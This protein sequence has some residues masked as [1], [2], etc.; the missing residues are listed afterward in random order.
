[1]LFILLF[2]TNTFAVEVS[3][4]HAILIDLDSGKTLYQ[5]D[6]Y[7]PVYPASTTKILTVIL[8]LENCDLNETVT[9]SFTAI[10]SVYAGGTTANIQEGET[11]TVRDL[12]CTLLVH[13]ANDAAYILAEHIGRINCQLCKYDE[14]SC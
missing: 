7:S 10:N 12:L 9:A 11:H 2:N 5:K 13:S 6:A 8:A 3:A 1:M 14:R 4:P